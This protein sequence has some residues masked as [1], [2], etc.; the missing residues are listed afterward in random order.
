MFSNLDDEEDAREQQQVS[1]KSSKLDQI[2]EF[3]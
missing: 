2:F 3:P 1:L